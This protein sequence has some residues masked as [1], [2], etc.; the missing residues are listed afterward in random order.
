M[1]PRW[2][3]TLIL[4][5]FLAH[6]KPHRLPTTKCGLFRP[7]GVFL[8]ALGR[9]S[10]TN[11]SFLK[12]KPPYTP[13]VLTSCFTGGFVGA[14]FSLIL[15]W[16]GI[17]LLSYCPSSWHWASPL[18]LHVICLYLYVG[19]AGLQAFYYQC[20]HN[21]IWYQDHD[22]KTFG[23]FSYMCSKILLVRSVRRS[24]SICV[25]HIGGKFNKVLESSD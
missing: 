2:P 6:R 3:L 7:Y 17:C 11:C 25:K 10:E 13:S 12:P 22:V 18:D 5:L 16:T 4:D 1:A 20:R 8:A 14:R 15:P 23:I 24:L 19:W 21:G 9:S